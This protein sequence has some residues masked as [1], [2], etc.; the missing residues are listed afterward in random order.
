M[1]LT[2]WQSLQHQWTGWRNFRYP[3]TA[4]L[5]AKPWHPD[6]DRA[7]TSVP[8]RRHPA[9]DRFIAHLKA[10]GGVSIGSGSTRPNPAGV[11]WG[12]PLNAAR[13]TDGVFV[14]HTHAGQGRLHVHTGG[15]SDY[16]ARFRY[17]PRML[18]AGNPAQN[19]ITTDAKL[20]IFDD[21][22]PLNP[23]ITEIQNF[24][25]F[26]GG[27]LQC[28]GVTHYNLNLDS[29]DAR[30]RSAAR[31][32]LA[33]QTLRFDDVMSGW[34]QRSTMGLAEG[35]RSDF[36]HPALATDGT[37]TSPD[38]PPYGL[39]LRLKPE[40]FE[41]LRRQGVTFDSNPQAWALLECYAGPGIIMVDRG[42]QNSTR[43]EPDNRWDQQDLRALALVGADDFD[44]W[45]A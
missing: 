21:T 28:D 12:Y 11:V 18:V 19:L 39:V 7:F 33:E 36:V 8:S 30:G 35:H 27:R 37:S 43:P 14:V 2:W 40:T 5:P 31:L 26:G 4:S 24:R 17:H 16:G 44:V 41:R 10:T 25:D 6:G 1:R 38:A 15:N 29:H 9:S 45:F 22:D 23:T 20:H 32:P 42:G 13:P 34:R 3:A